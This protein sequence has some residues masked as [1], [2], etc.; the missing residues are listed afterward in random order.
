MDNFLLCF[1]AVF[2]LLLLMLLGYWLKHIEFIPKSGFDAIDKLCFKIFVPVML[3][4]NVYNADFSQ[5][6]H[7]DATIF[8]ELSILGIFLV[9]FWLVPRLIPGSRENIATV[10]HGVCHG[11]LA[12]L[13][14]PLISNLFGDSGMAVYSILLACTSPLINPLMVFEHVYFQGEQIKPAK[15]IA[16]VFRSPFLV[17]TLAGL[18][19]KILGLQFPVFFQTTISNI[20]A[21]ASPLCLIALG[22]SFAF[23]SSQSMTRMVISSVL[24]KCILIP[25]VVLGVAIVLG[26]R[27]IILAS[28]LVIFSCPSAAATYSFC[29]GYCGNPKLASQIVVY[30]TVF[31]IFTMFW[32]LF[33]F[34]QLR[35]L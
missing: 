9:S 19:S 30:T 15:L 22:G 29:T 35:L 3:F 6:F 18:A 33:L 16:Q 14:I 25:G 13:G 2:P 4:S 24:A 28:L 34:L 5:Q 17:G 8:M 31:S 27:G 11:N 23:S 20:K 26:F 7:L 32:W 10:V 12:V 1:N 21:I